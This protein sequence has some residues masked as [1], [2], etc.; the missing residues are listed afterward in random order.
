[1]GPRKTEFTLQ[2]IT[3]FPGGG[4][5]AFDGSGRR[6]AWVG[7]HVAAEKEEEQEHGRVTKGRD[8]SRTVTTTAVA[9]VVGREKEGWRRT[10]EGPQ[11]TRT[12]R[13]QLW[14]VRAT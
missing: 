1:M 13:E 12:E 3:F 14:S 11:T 8:T 6:R 7:L 4:A 10:R 9:V 2:H 5:D